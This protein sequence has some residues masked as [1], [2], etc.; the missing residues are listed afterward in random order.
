MF[1]PSMRAVAMALLLVFAWAGCAK[2]HD[3]VVW[4]LRG[5]GTERVYA[6]TA[7]QAWSIS[8]AILKLEPTEA[9]EEHRSEGYMLTSDD[10]SALVPSTYMGVFI[11]AEGPRAAKVTFVTRRR[12]PTQ[13][14]AGL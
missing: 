7:D 3:L 8:K 10:S 4:K 5:R 6:L 9:I 13:A 14:Y 12:T 11:A 2:K 1:G